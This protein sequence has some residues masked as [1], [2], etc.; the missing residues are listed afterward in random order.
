[1]WK[2]L[3]IFM[4]K[5][6]L[7]F[8]I[9]AISFLASS[10]SWQ[11]S[12]Y[13]V[14]ES[15]SAIDVEYILLRDEFPAKMSL[16]NW[17]SWFGNNKIWNTVHSNDFQHDLK[18]HA[19]KITIGPKEILKF[20]E[21]NDACVTSQMKERFDIKRVKISG[22]KGTII[23]EGDKFFQQFQRKGDQYTITYK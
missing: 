1:L 22:K 18:T 21:D 12:F 14:N 16:E 23:Y 5:L 4:R 6:L 15:D 19:Y 10:C 9:F 13:V 2:L 20:H 11:V 17:N 8:L 7:I 3:E